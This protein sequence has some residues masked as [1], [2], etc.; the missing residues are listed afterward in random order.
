MS[1]LLNIHNLC[2]QKIIRNLS[3]KVSRGDFIIILGH[4][5]SGKSTF[6]NCLNGKN[7]I[8]EGSIC[9]DD[10]PISTLSIEKRALF[11]S[12]L[13]QE[14]QLFESLTVQENLAML[15][16]Y[17]LKDLPPD[18]HKQFHL[19]TSYLSGGQRQSLAMTMAMAR[20][21]Q[22]LLLDEHTSALDPKAAT[23]SM[24]KVDDLSKGNQDLAIL[25]TTHSLDI[26]L[27]YGNRL[28]MIQHGTITHDFAAQE[29]ALL[30]KH[31]LY[32]IY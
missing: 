16:S 24:K 15:P 18:L 13:S 30:T 4:N 22:I 2:Y 1:P 26:A 3:L 11:L 28:L 17:E 21:P 9:I 29:K 10:V 23:T 8:D 6:L 32:S 5:G 20:N 27:Q 31:D 12:T 25:M 14:T 7:A 19:P